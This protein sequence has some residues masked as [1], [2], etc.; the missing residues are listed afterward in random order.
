[1]CIFLHVP[2]C[3]T[4]N[5]FFGIP[6]EEKDTGHCSNSSVCDSKLKINTTEDQTT[7]NTR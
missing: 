7:F 3:R 4:A 1:M 5:G 6:T 2:T